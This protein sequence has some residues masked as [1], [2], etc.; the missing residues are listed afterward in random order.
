MED[1]HF[2]MKIAIL[3]ESKVGKTPL[4]LG[5]STD[6]KGDCTPNSSVNFQLRL[7]HKE[8]KS[9]LVQLWD[10][11]GARRH[12]MLSQYY[13]AGAAGLIFVFDV[14]ETGSL[15]KLID[16]EREALKAA[17]SS[18]VKI[19]VGNT[20]R[21]NERKKEVSSEAAQAFAV[22]HG[23]FLMYASD[24]SEFDAAIR[25]TLSRIMDSVPWPPEPSLLL[26]HGI[27]VGRKLADDPQYREALFSLSASS[28]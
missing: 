25:M 17:C 6:A 12:L 23:M 16:W 14:T 7:Y 19:L 22:K 13:S 9:H 26:S 15:E 20:W 28:A 18:C 5:S 11:K 4:L 27:K 10:V 1:Y 21:C 2:C 24:V 3:G 8:G